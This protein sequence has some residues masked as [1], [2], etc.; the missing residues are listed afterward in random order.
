MFIQIKL[1]FLLTHNGMKPAKYI[2]E[3]E[4]T[5]EVKWDCK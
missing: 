3:R 2:K 1:Y 5:M 4:I